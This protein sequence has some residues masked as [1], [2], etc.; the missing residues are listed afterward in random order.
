MLMLRKWINNNKE[1]N[2]EYHKQLLGKNLMW[3]GMMLV[4]F[5]KQKKFCNKLW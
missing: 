1:Y 2:K 4:G 3:N 5:N